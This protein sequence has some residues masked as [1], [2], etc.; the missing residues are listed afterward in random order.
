MELTKQTIMDARFTTMDQKYYVA[1]EVDQFL[2]AL[3]ELV[4]QKEQEMQ[5]LKDQINTL[6][7]QESTPAHGGNEMMASAVQQSIE[8]L[9]VQQSRMV[10]TNRS[11]Y[12]NALAFKEEMAQHFSALQKQT[13]QAIEMLAEANHMEIQ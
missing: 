1:S 8:A 10:A 7:Q 2:D 4:D 6:Q 3:A 11:I 5:A 9:N 12:Y 13:D